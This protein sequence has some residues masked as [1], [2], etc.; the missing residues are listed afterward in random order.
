MNCKECGKG[1]TV[2]VTTQKSTGSY[3]ERR[4]FLPWL[5]F[6]PWRI[7]KWLFRFGVQSEKETP[8]KETMWRCNYCGQ[9]FK[10]DDTETTT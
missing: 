9:S 4:G 8:H 7:L 2:R 3:V 1:T 6:L 10:D 5:I